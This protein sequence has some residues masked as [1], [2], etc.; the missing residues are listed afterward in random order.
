VV[1]TFRAQARAVSGAINAALG[2]FD[3][4]NRELETARRLFV[5]LGDSNGRGRCDLWL[6]ELRLR[7]GEFND[8]EGPL[9]DA[10]TCFR[11]NGD[12]SM[13]AVVLDL[14]SWLASRRG[15]PDR[16]VR[17]SG[18]AVAMRHDLGAC[19]SPDLKVMTAG[20]VDDARTVVGASAGEIWREG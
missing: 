1:P 16:A 7:A 8:A 3:V 20:H 11:D 9:V 18:A 13:I 2:L 12:L 10:L 17:L 6:G 15:D 14:L 5:E 19:Q 4:G